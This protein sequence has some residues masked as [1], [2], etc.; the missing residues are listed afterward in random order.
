MNG[1]LVAGIVWLAFI[2]A[3]YVAFD[4]ATQPAA[5]AGCEDGDASQV[6]RLDAA[7]DGHYYVDGAID[8]KAVRFVVDTGA[9]TVTVGAPMRSASGCP[10]GIPPDSAR[11][12]ATSPGASCAVAAS[13]RVASTFRACRSP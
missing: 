12:P 4:Y 10:K 7:R 1:H 11:P 9:T 6:L 8:G 13:V 2:A 3:G 5:V